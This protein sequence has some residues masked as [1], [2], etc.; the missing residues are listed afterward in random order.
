MTKRNKLS[1]DCKIFERILTLLCFN[2]GSLAD[3]KTTAII[4]STD[5]KT[6]NFVYL[7]KKVQKKLNA[8]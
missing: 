8:V 7:V 5:C 6:F 2:I 1:T 4:S 3:Y